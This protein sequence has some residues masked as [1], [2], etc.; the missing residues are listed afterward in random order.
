[1]GLC[2]TYI[3]NRNDTYMKEHIKYKNIHISLYCIVRAFKK[4]IRDIEKG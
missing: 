4:F 1:M 2:T 3:L